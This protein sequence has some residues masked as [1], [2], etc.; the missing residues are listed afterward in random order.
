VTDVSW[1]RAPEV[2]QSCIDSQWFYFWIK[3]ESQLIRRSSVHFSD[4]DEG[5]GDTESHTNEIL[6]RRLL[7]EHKTLDLHLG[8]L[9]VGQVDYWLLRAVVPQSLENKVLIGQKNL[10]KNYLFWIKNGI[11]LVLNKNQN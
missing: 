7:D 6:I 5:H 1:K 3:M 2:L 10:S 11:V 4:A 8:F 9:Q